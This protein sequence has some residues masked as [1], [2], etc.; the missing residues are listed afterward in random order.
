MCYLHP[1][2]RACQDDYKE[3][4][5]KCYFFS[6]NELTWDDARTYCM[7]EDGYDLVVIH[8][9]SLNRF[10][11]NWDIVNNRTY[12]I[13]LQ[14]KNQEAHFEWVNGQ[15]LGYGKPLGK[16]PWKAREPNVNTLF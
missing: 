2:A 10:L 1:L 6:S 3:Y 9:S 8:N 5:G 11:S 16:A 14:D 13:G 12:W 4:D 15:A 7:V